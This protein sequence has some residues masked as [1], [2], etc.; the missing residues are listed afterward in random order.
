[1]DR[2]KLV[3]A[4]GNRHKARELELAVPEWSVELLDV[5]SFPD[6]TGAT[7]YDNARAKACF[8]RAAGPADAWIL[9]EDSG[10]EVDVLGGRPGIFSARFAGENASD[11]E[12]VSKLLDELAAVPD[13][14]RAARYVCELVAIA[15]SAEEVRVTGTLDG[16]VATA[17][18]GTAG[19]GYDPVFVPAGGERTVAELGDAWK[20]RHSHRARAAA[21][22]RD[23]LRRWSQ[24]L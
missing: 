19:F 6:E 7:F 17:P 10:I 15:P 18:R 16:S 4:S 3:L 11:A 21:L 9:G 14:E 20:S 13:E 5:D 22:L 1:M 2:L 12:N 23:A 24:P 8:G